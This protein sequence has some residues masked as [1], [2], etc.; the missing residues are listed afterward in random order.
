MLL[1]DKNLYSS[2]SNKA[3]EIAKNFTIEQY[4]KKLLSAY[5]EV[6]N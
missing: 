6:L 5:E 2:L 3:K 1:S 4:V